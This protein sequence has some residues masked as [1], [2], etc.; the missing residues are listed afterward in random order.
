[1]RDRIAEWVCA[2]S[3]GR[4]IALRYL[5][6]MMIGNVVWEM[7][8]LPLYTLW[9]T[10]TAGYLTFVVLHCSLGDL[11]IASSALLGAVIIGGQGFSAYSS[12]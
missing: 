12:D 10:A 1:M 2:R 3:A 8:Q 4:R 5:V 9:Q 11:I 6:A 7:L